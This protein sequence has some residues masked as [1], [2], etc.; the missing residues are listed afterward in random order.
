M[1]RKIYEINEL[2]NTNDEE[3]IKLAIKINES[4]KI[5][6]ENCDEDDK[7]DYNIYND[8]EKYALKLENKN[9]KDNKKYIKGIE[10]TLKLNSYFCN[11]TIQDKLEIFKLENNIK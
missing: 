5:A 8:L 6:R 10:K 1:N 2:Y 9:I 4:E 3:L 7:K 11:E